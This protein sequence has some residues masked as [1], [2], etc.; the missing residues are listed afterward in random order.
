MVFPSDNPVSPNVAKG[1]K[2]VLIEW[3][4]WEAGLCLECKKPKC[5]IDATDCCA[6]WLLL[7]QPDFLEQKSSVQEVI[8]AAGHLC[9]FLPKFHC[10]LNF[11]EFFWG[12]VKKYLHSKGF[13][14]QHSQDHTGC[15]DLVIAPVHADRSSISL[16]DWE[17]EV[18]AHIF[19]CIPGIRALAKMRHPGGLCEMWLCLHTHFLPQFG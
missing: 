15:L 6:R 2:Q 12:A 3:G 10:E 8:E 9:I 7:Q 4:L 14:H 18:Y 19:D 1:I 13:T 16:S 17:G 5:S 11:I